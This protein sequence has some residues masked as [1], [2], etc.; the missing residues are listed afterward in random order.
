MKN[1][2]AQRYA[3]EM[4]EL[5][6]T[7]EERKELG[8]PPG[9]KHPTKEDMAFYDSITS[10]VMDRLLEFED[11]DPE[12]E[13]QTKTKRPGRDCTS[14]VLAIGKR[15]KKYKN[16]VKAAR[17]D[18]METSKKVSRSFDPTPLIPGCREGGLQ[19][20]TP[21]NNKSIKK[22]FARKATDDNGPPSKRSCL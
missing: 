22:M 2:S 16:I 18:L 4:I 12:V 7:A 6:I 19:V 3:C 20:G 9:P 11:K 15:V 8:K 14:T 5:V 21:K 17:P 1:K 10:R 13:R